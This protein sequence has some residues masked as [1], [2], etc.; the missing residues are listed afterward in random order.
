MELIRGKWEE[1]ET[2][3]FQ[4]VFHRETERGRETYSRVRNQNEKPEPL[5]HTLR[6]FCVSIMHFPDLAWIWSGVIAFSVLMR[7][8]RI[9]SALWVKYD[10]V[11]L[12][13]S[14]QISDHWNSY[15]G[16]LHWCVRPCFHHQR[17]NAVFRVSESWKIDANTLWSW[18]NTT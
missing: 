10:N 8:I 15:R 2:P 3:L 9:H 17:R 13:H 6:G 1:D 5:I 16:G 12:C 14:H 7:R 18:S 11:I 4:T